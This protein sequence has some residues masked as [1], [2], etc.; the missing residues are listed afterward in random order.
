MARFGSEAIKNGVQAGAILAAGTWAVF[1][2]GVDQDRL[3][4]KLNAQVE[5]E[6]GTLI[7]ARRDLPATLPVALQ[8]TLSN[9]GEDPGQVALAIL[10]V[11][12]NIHAREEGHLRPHFVAGSGP[13]VTFAEIDWL[14]DSLTVSYEYLAP[15]TYLRAREIFS[16][17]TTAFVPDPGRFDSLSWFLI[18]FAMESCTN[19]GTACPSV[20]LGVDGFAGPDCMGEPIG[21]GYCGQFH[22]RQPDGSDR[23]VTLAELERDHAMTI[24][25]HEGLIP[26][27]L[28]PAAGTPTPVAS[29][30]P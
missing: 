28:P 27:A 11:S 18:I 29:T 23:P 26:L 17:A 22:L 4:F 25:T 21:G 15:S 2:F 1:E 5:A 12:G 16:T 19:F 14:H 6:V 7:A 20:S 3:S 10:S 9:V 30:T 13:G 24:Y 8:A